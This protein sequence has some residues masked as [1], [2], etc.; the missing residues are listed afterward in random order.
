MKPNNQGKWD[1]SRVIIEV[2]QFD[3]Y[4]IKL[5]GSGRI[6]MRNRKFLCKYMPFQPSPSVLQL[7]P[8]IIIPAT[9]PIMEA[10]HQMPMLLTLLRTRPQAQETYRLATLAWRLHFEEPIPATPTHRPNRQLLQSNLCCFSTYD[11]PTRR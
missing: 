11:P 4:Y 6:T 2:K 8:S 1:R 7:P 10:P 5:D 3:Q 9:L